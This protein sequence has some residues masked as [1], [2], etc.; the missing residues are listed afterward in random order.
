MGNGVLSFEK[1]SLLEG[2]VRLVDKE[3]SG[4]EVGGLVAQD[5]VICHIQC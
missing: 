2:A 1:G 3:A 5:K 4:V